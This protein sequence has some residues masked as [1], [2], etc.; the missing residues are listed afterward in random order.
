MVRRLFQP[1]EVRWGIAAGALAWIPAAVAVGPVYAIFFG[2]VAGALIG[3]GMV[4]LRESRLER[5]RADQERDDRVT[6][7]SR[8]TRQRAGLESVRVTPSEPLGAASTR[9]RSAQR[10]PG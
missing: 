4:V 9:S 5:A 7:R 8:V 10:R 3:Q 1:V 6:R 2:A